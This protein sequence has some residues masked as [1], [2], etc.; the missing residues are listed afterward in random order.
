M[1]VRASERP[2]FSKVVRFIVSGVTILKHKAIKKNFCFIKK[3]VLDAEFAMLVIKKLVL[4]AV[5]VLKTVQQAQ[6]KLL[7]KN[8]PHKKYTLKFKKILLFTAKKAASPFQA[9]SV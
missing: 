6:E 4:L 2:C 9:E 3:S 1:M 5:R 7:A 8:I